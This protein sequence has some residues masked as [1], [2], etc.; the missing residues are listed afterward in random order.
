MMMKEKTCILFY[1]KFPEKGKVKTR[2]DDNIGKAK[3]L[4]LY[5][6]FVIDSLDTL[7]RLNKPVIV[8]YIP[9][10]A[11]EEIRQWLGK[12]YI[13]SLQLG[14]N[15][16]MRMKN[17]FKQALK[18]GYEKVIIIGSDSPD[19][20]LAF[21]KK[22]IEMLDKT[23]AVIG[24][25]EDGGYYLLGFTKSGFSPMVFDDIPWSTPSVFSKTMK[26][27]RDLKITTSSL[28][29]WRDVDTFQDLIS[30]V[31]RNKNSSFS[32]SLTMK[33]ISSMKIHDNTE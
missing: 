19:L 5:K 6:A 14:K 23:E 26:K 13:Y 12:D 3:T 7:K 30:L 2:L 18:K 29:A 32:K 17:S 33:L 25:S 1:L 10:K 16:G 21:L 9:N 24:P 11:K 31:K 20:P 8:C 28:P 22:A 27:L 15:L 4:K